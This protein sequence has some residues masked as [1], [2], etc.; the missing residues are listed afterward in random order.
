MSD[1]RPRQFKEDFFERIVNVQ[2]EAEPEVY[3][4]TGTGAPLIVNGMVIGDQHA[5]VYTSDDGMHWDGK[6]LFQ[7]GGAGFGALYGGCWMRVGLNPKSPPVWVMVGSSSKM[8]SMSA[9]GYS[10][11]GKN[12]GGR[13]VFDERHSG[14][15][16]KFE[17]D[18]ISFESQFNFPD[19]HVDNFYSS[20]GQSWH[21][22]H[23]HPLDSF[24]AQAM[25]P[26]MTGFADIATPPPSVSRVTRVQA[27][28][29]AGFTRRWVSRT[30]SLLVP[31]D[32]SPE[33]LATDPSSGVQT[34]S[35][36]IVF[37]G[38]R[39]KAV[40][41]VKKGKHVGKLLAIEISPYHA[42]S[43]D[44]GAHGYSTVRIS[45]A[46][47]KKSLGKANIGIKRSTTIGYG[48]YVFVVGGGD[49]KGSTMVSYTEDGIHWH[50]QTLGAHYQINPVLAGPRE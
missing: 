2:W 16:V 49:G 17:G 13:T 4:M 44:D 36:Q 18:Q 28:D 34:K 12:F 23:Y 35:D 26:T 6:D 43:P 31:E 45:D 38:E 1:E 15:L 24:A 21:P 46:K 30:S 20:D 10:T 41:R 47:T 48:H 37:I 50:P 40:G 7:S 8:I 32:N 5:W 14:E 3:W 27:S 9:A 42:W 19:W 11:D 25:P 39:I 22:D 33:L 29:P